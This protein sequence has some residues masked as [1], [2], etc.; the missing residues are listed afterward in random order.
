METKIILVDLD[1]TLL[2]SDSTLSQRTIE[3]LKQCQDA[4]HLIGFCTSR[5]TTRLQKYADVIHP[6][7]LICNAGACVY[8]KDKLIYSK[9]F[10]L[11]QTHTLLNGVYSICGPDAEI[12]VDTLDDFFWNRTENK[13]TQ[14]MPEA[15]FHTFKDFPEP[16]M[17]FC[18]QM[19]EEEKAN[20]I[21]A[22][23]P[24]CSAILFSDI[25]WYKFSPASATK[26]NGII[27]LSE[28]LNVPLSQ[29][30]SFGDDFADIGML[31]TTGIGVAMGNAIPQVKE[32]ATAH[33]LSCDEDGVAVYLEKNIL[34]K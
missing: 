29:M 13:S 23:V 24:D 17:K 15:K 14:Y 32:I 33:T 9:T 2:R 5:G 26:E 6:E 11:E 12:T 22:L 18:V 10:S 27:F 20:K 4:G 1:L 7:I 16:A 21:A 19:T 8:Y 28:Y 31:K 25:P 34:N 3:T 30:I